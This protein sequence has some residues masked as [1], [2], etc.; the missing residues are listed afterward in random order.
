MNNINN[1]SVVIVD[2]IGILAHLYQYAKIAYIGGAFGSGLHN[3][4]EPVTFG[5]PVIFGTKF[6]NFQEAS[7]LIKLKGAFSVK[8]SDE[9]EIVLLKLTGEDEMYEK[10]CSIN[11]EYVHQNIGASDVILKYLSKLIKD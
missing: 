2:S 9:L 8:N 11:K 6:N 1:F 3:I 10:A 5:I 7:D 4:Q